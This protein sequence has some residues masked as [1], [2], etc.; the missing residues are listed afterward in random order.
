[1]ARDLDLSEPED[2]METEEYALYREPPPPDDTRPMTDEYATCREIQTG[3]ARDT[4]IRG[5]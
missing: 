3:A 1:M 4:E 2:A 5:Q